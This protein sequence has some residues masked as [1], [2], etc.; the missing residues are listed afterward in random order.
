MA[1]IYV[2]TLEKPSPRHQF[3]SLLN[4][5]TFIASRIVY[6]HLVAICFTSSFP[7]AYKSLPSIKSILRACHFSCFFL[8]LFLSHTF[9]VGL[10]ELKSI[11]SKSL[12]MHSLCSLITHFISC[13]ISAK[14]VS[15]LLPCILYLSYYF[16]PEVNT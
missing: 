9:F 6:Q 4:N 8:P 3:I 13:W 2:P 16:Q 11:F 15:G 10:R 7:A 5:I 14:F 1:F 12:F